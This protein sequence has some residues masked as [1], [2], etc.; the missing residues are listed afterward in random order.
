MRRLEKYAVGFDAGSSG[1]PK[2]PAIRL[3]RKK[4][5]KIMADE[6]RSSHPPLLR[7]P[8]LL[9]RTA[10][11]VPVAAAGGFNSRAQFTFATAL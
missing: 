8:P 6:I 5:A 4:S 10:D 11:D 9:R 7:P 3:D 1:P 2:N